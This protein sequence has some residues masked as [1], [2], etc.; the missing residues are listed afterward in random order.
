[1]WLYPVPALVA[2]VGWLYLIGTQSAQQQL[3]ALVF[4]IGGVVCYFG[5]RKVA[6]QP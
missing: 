6:P 3:Y 2:L 5:W 1:M 4:L